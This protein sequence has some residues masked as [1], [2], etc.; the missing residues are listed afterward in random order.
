MVIAGFA[1]PSLGYAAAR[2]NISRKEK[3]RISFE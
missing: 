2:A 3:E 1:V